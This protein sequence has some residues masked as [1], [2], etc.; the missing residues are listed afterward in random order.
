MNIWIPRSK[1]HWIAANKFGIPGNPYIITG[2]TKASDG[3][4]G[5]TSYPMNSS[6]SGQTSWQALDGKNW[7]FR[8]T[9]YSEPNGDYS[10][11]CWLGFYDLDPNNIRFNDASC[12]YH[13][14]DYLCS[15]NDK[16]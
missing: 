11:N 10:A 1:N 2:V 4:G 6:S 5:C 15:T 3:C 8:D 16:Y 12:V 14:T 13:S 9:S 7:W